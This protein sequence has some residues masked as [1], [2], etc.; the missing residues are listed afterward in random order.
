MRIT[1]KQINYIINNRKAILNI[2]ANEI[3]SNKYIEFYVNENYDK[4]K[5]EK[6]N[7]K[8]GTLRSFALDFTKSNNDFNNFISI[9]I[10]YKILWCDSKTYFN[11]KDSVLISKEVIN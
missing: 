9:P 1:E 4:F 7:Y 8:K 2:A 6:L 5:G 11:V 10:H 3:E